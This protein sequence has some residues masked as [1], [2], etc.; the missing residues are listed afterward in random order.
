MVSGVSNSGYSHCN[1]RTLT[2]R[3]V[4]SV[5]SLSPGILRG[6]PVLQSTA[7]GRYH[8][9]EEGCLVAMGTVAVLRGGVCAVVSD[10][11]QRT[12]GYSH[13]SQLYTVCNVSVTR[14]CC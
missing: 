14:G 10:G 6:S 3:C 4:P 1:C 11:E 5:C 2:L 8:R 9:E 7:H 13:L 12:T